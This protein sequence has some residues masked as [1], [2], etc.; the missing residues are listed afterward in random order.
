MRLLHRRIN[1]IK[2]Y[3][4]AK[5]LKIEKLLEKAEGIAIQHRK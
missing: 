3:Y 4:V 5:T 2:P 1:E